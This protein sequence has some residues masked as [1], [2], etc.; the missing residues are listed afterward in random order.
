MISHWLVIGVDAPSAGYLVLARQKRWRAG[1]LLARYLS[2]RKQRHAPLLT[3]IGG[4]E[5]RRACIA[6]AILI[7]YRHAPTLRCI[8]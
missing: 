2:P 8:N 7:F 4:L 3:N 1:L 5:R 6:H